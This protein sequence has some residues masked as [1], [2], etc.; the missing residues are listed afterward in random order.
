MR[1]WILA[2]T[3]SLDRLFPQ[4]GELIIATTAQRSGAHL[5]EQKDE[6]ICQVHGGEHQLET[7]TTWEWAIGSTT[8]PTRDRYLKSEYKYKSSNSS[9]SHSWE[10]PINPLADT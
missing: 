3:S 8:Q 10:G 6:Q 9:N 1:S 2:S 7:T 4:S 5:D